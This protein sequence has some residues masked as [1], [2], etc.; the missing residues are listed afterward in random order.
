MYDVSLETIL[1]Y[2]MCSGTRLNREPELLIHNHNYLSLKVGH[3][4]RDFLSPL[5]DMRARHLL[6]TYGNLV[7]P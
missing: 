3:A 6:F 5:K 2:A 1:S 4:I 7:T